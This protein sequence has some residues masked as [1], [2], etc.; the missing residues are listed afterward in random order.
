VCI[1]E[2]KQ[3]NDKS[4]IISIT[5]NN[6]NYNEECELC[7]NEC[8]YQNVLLNLMN[9]IKFDLDFIFDPTFVSIDT[10]KHMDSGVLAS[11]Y[12]SLNDF[13]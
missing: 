1:Y 11:L 13:G 4:N 2:Q 5:Q 3:V 6:L 10:S 12:V 8:N 7:Q 9:F